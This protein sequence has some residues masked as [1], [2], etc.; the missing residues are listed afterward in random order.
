MN[1]HVEWINPQ[2]EPSYRSY[3]LVLT[4]PSGKSYRVEKILPTKKP[5]K[6]ELNEI[7]L[8]EIAIIELEL[9]PIA[10]EAQITEE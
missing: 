9:Q 5:T 4:S 1:W 6:S 3:V 10:P 2:I 8:R 7:A